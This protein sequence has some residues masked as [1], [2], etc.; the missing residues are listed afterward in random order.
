MPTDAAPPL[1]FVPRNRRRVLL[2]F[3]RYSHSFGT[4]DHAFPLVGGVRAFMPP[5]GILLVASL[6]PAEWQVKFV[7]EN[8]RPAS[9]EEL[10]WADVA[11]ISGM[12]VQRRRIG[13]I[14]R[15]AHAAGTLT[16]L[17]GPSASAAPEWYP[18]VDLLHCGEV[19]DGT[20][21][22]FERLDASIA[23]PERQEIFRTAERLPMTDFPSPAY[24]LIDVRQYLLGSV[25]FSSG[26]PY[27]CEFCDIPALYGRN[28]RLKTPGQI[29]RELD[30]MVDGGTDSI[31]FVDD[32]FVANPKATLE[33]LPHLVAWQK[34]HDFRAVLSCEATL[35][36]AS[37][38]R[39]LELMRD[40]GFATV[41]CGIE[42]PEPPALRAMNKSQ[43]LRAPIL[44]S[45][46]ALNRHGLE[47]A[48]GI[49]LGLDTDTPGTAQAIIDFARESQI[50]ILTVNLLY[51][52]PHTPLHDRLERAGRI[53]PDEDRDSNI[54]F[55]EPYEVVLERWR[56]VIVELYTPAAVL[57]RYATQAAHTYPNRRRPEQPWRQL[58][59]RNL[60]RAAGT[61]FRLVWRVGVMGDYRREFWTM[62]LALA[63]RGDMTVLFR[64]S[65]VAHH[66]ITY[67]RECTRG[68]VQ[69]S[70]YS[71]RVLDGDASASADARLSALSV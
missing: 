58:T 9:T 34:R 29:V 17:G 24:H 15:R 42:T 38:P 1:G 14:N 6:L 67:A 11:F 39:I 48:S 2:V 55:L 54:E 23:R 36:I 62:F 19:G 49:I 10:E 65:I 51:A 22:L 18:E 40:A 60:R 37:H 50:P 63:R 52:L 53:V 44:E 31:Y 61:L 28:P 4:F 27:R 21:R 68:Q 57:A 43:N 64:A 16:V 33:L 5:Q 70:N 35:N 69:S 56:R 41:F 46:R 7:D 25:Q 26:C 12:H 13:E 47:V 45:I 71:R 32:N 30:Q 20:L 66:L 8:I 3:P 59:W